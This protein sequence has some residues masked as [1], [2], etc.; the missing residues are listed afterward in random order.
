MH[1][2]NENRVR[3]DF[4]KALEVALTLFL[5]SFLWPREHRSVNASTASLLY[6]RQSDLYLG[7]ITL[8][9]STCVFACDF[10][11]NLPNV[12]LVVNINFCF[13]FF[14]RSCRSM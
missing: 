1:S 6:Q 3:D 2:C 12:I 11:D 7:R 5:A 8:T 10:H 14:T 13:L 9:K 4:S